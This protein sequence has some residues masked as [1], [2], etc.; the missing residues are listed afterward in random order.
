MQSQQAIH[1][2]F[3]DK[4]ILSLS[5]FIS[6]DIELLFTKV[7]EMKKLRNNKEASRLLSGTIASLLFF[8]PSSRTIS[9]FS[10]ALKLLDCKT[11]EMQNVQV[12]S[13]A[14]G[15][16]FEDTIRVFEAY[17][18]LIII[19]HKDAGSAQQA[20]DIAEIPIINAGDGGASHPTQTLLDLYTIQEKFGRLTGLKVVACG[21]VLH[22][23]TIH[24]LIEGLSLFSNN[25]VYLLSPDELKFTK[26]EFEKFSKLGAKILE[27]TSPDEIPKDTHVFY[28]NR[29]QKERFENNK[30]A[31][32]YSG[33]FPLTSQFLEQYGN[34]D[35]IILD[36]L[37]RVDEIASE[38]DQNPRA[39]YLKN[40]LKN[41]LYIRMA[42]AGLV[43]GRL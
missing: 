17:S 30:E 25:E 15:E 27:I 18:D 31:E 38:I 4:D 19:R 8:E 22:S 20:S 28:W 5:Q 14:K 10:A 37:P 35:L 36:P 13:I 11:I 40:Q 21:D 23:R 42:L 6:S 39:L 33:Q 16:S 29:I 24:S 2:N 12:S 9:S 26:S 1:G 34:N 3:A 32:K 43:L 41:G 7:P